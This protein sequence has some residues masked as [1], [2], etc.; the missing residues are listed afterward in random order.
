M[1][2]DTNGLSAT[3]T[4]PT[5]SIE[6]ALGTLCVKNEKNKYC[7]VEFA[8]FGTKYPKKPEGDLGCD[9]GAVKALVGLGCCFGSLIQMNAEKASD[10]AEM[11]E[12]S[13]WV[14]KCGGTMLPCSAGA[15]KDV[16]VVS[17]SL[18]L[19]GDGLTQEAMEKPAVIAG[20]KK[21]LADTLKV[22]KDLVIV[23]KI[24]V[25]VKRERR[26]RARALSLS[27]AEIEFSVIVEGGSGSAKAN[28]VKDSIGKVDNT[29]LTAAITKD[30]ALSSIAT[31]LTATQSR[32]V[33][34]DT[35][36]AKPDAENGA[37]AAAPTH[38]FSAIFVGIVLAR[39]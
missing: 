23:Q 21:V 24:T 3:P 17:S 18:S 20:I 22:K 29:V 30:P 27:T 11:E 9:S 15:I 32:E 38:M 34:T 37:M 19:Q 39:T 10:K 28:A 7:M 12:L 16:S 5:E 6:K 2:G 33:K 4:D 25:T 31:G 26:G 35:A 1:G 14:S 13:Y 8:A 36:I